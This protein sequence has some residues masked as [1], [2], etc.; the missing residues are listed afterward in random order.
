MIFFCTKLPK[1]RERVY[2]FTI[3]FGMSIYYILPKFFVSPSGRYYTLLFLER[4][5]WAFWKTE[6][7]WTTVVHSCPWPISTSEQRHWER[8]REGEREKEREREREGWRENLIQMAT[9]CEYRN[10]YIVTPQFLPK[11]DLWYSSNYFVQLWE[12]FDVAIL[13]QGPKEEK[14]E[15]LKHWW[16]KER[17]R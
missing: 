11:V 2:S 3:N 5:R 15:Q 12:T 7:G 1:L 13:N 10:L 16:R 4:L 9:I 17:E 14:K 6:R 8:E